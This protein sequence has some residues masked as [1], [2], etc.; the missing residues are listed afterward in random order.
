MVKYPFN[1][2]KY[3]DRRL[4]DLQ[5]TTYILL[6]DI[7]TKVKNKE[8]VKIKDYKGADITLSVLVECYCAMLRESAAKDYSKFMYNKLIRKMRELIQGLK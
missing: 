1:I 7:T 3:K 2:I 5:E 4:Y 6:S 8:L